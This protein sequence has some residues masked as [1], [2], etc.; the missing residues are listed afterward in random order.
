MG[1]NQEIVGIK[2]VKGRTAAIFQI[3][4]SAG[5]PKDVLD[6]LGV[7]GSRLY[8]KQP[9]HCN[10]CQS[11]EMATLELIGVASRPLFWECNDC[12][13]LWCK[14]ERGWIEER[15]KRLDNVWTNVHDWEPPDFDF[16]N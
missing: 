13:A 7:V 4:E 1:K 15:I 9:K 3:V 6:S 11:S 12:G 5:T 16:L 2:I 14:E 10:I 8:K